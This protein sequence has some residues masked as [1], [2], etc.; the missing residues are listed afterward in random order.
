VLI[1]APD[2]WVSF[3]PCTTLTTI[4]ALR[5]GRPIY[6]LAIF[7]RGLGSIG[8]LYTSQYVTTL[9]VPSG[10]RGLDNVAN[11]ERLTPIGAGSVAAPGAVAAAGG[12]A[13]GAV[14]AATRAPLV[15]GRTKAAAP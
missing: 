12:V 14:V 1:L 13:A 7:N 15:S 6:A 4:E 9:R 8:G 5:S 3:R 2:D 10:G 11:L